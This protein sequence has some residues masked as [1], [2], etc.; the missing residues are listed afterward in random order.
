MSEKK[1]YPN[2]G[3][4]FKNDDKQ[5]ANHPD[6]K[7]SAE[8]GGVEHWISGW[9]KTG[10]KGQFLSLSFKPKEAQQQAQQRKPAG[11]DDPW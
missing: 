9:K 11:D 4:L 3:I 8:I 7:G 2:S 1:K 10:T 5:E 6:Y